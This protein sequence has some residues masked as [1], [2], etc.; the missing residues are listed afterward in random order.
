MPQGAFDLRN[1]AQWKRADLLFEGGGLDQR[2][3]VEVDDACAAHPFAAAKPD[4]LRDRTDRRG[5]LRLVTR[6][7]IS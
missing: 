5:D 3:V 1:P 6:V 7:R 2:D 4:F